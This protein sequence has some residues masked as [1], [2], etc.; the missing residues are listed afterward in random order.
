ML[1]ALEGVLKLLVHE[2]EINLPGVSVILRMREEVA[3]LRH[4]V[5]KLAS[6]LRRRG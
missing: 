3:T 4:H 6:E 5:E 1:N 2:L